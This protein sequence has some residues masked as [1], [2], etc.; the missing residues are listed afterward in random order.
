MGERRGEG[1]YIKGEE[2]PER[3]NGNV[4]TQDH[5]RLHGVIFGTLLFRGVVVLVGV[6]DTEDGG[7][8]HTSQE[9]SEDIQPEITETGVD[10]TIVFVDNRESE[11]NGRV[12]ATSGHRPG[13][14]RGRH[15]GESN[16]K[17]EERVSGGGIGGC[18]VEDDRN[19]GKGVK[20][21]DRKGCE[22]RKLKRE[23]NSQR[24]ENKKANELS[25]D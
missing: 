10:L 22:G 11:T 12:E 25:R 24:I 19:E 21:F 3:A 7:S 17:A 14:E 18:D 13:R 2:K 20:D 16:T 1:T 6:R 5:L 15:D 9:R 4:E 23:E 8:K